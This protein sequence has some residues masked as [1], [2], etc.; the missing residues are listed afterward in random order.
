MHCISGVRRVLLTRWKLTRVVVV[1]DLVDGGVVQHVQLVQVG[2]LA[3]VPRPATPGG[4]LD[5]PRQ[6]WAVIELLE[7]F[8]PR[9]ASLG[10]FLL[11]LH[12][13]ATET[14]DVIVS[15][16]VV[17]LI[18]DMISYQTSNGCHTDSDTPP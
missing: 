12:G 18:S 13:A 8:R 6:L 5:A 15:D 4:H 11:L 9:P 16:V 3:L 2:Q 10:H 7:A 17:V 14:Y 1:I